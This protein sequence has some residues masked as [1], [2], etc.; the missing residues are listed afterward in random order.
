MILLTNSRNTPRW[1]IA[2]SITKILK[3]NDEW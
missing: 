1:V 3:Q 2:E